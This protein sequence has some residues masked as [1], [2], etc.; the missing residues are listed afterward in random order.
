MDNEIYL[1]GGCFWGM[2]RLMRS[3]PGVT[4]VV[5]GYAQDRET[6]N[7]LSPGAVSYECVCAGGT[8]LKEAVKV[9]FD[10]QAVSL[11]AILFAYFRA[12]DPTVKNRQGHDIGE[13]YQTG[14][15]Y[16]DFESGQTVQRI[17]AVERERAGRFEVEIRP[18]VAFYEA[19]DYHQRY[20]EKNPGG[21][22]HIPDALIES[23]SHMT[24]DPG[25]YQRAPK[26][27][28]EGLLTKLQYDVTQNAATEPPFHN[29]YWN[30]F[31]RGIY[32]DVVTGEP[33][34]TSRDKFES[35][36]G[37]PS[38]SKPLDEGAVLKIPDHSH[39]MRRTEVKSRAGNSHLGHVFS[40][41]VE[42]PTGTRY[43]INSAALRFIPYEEMEEQGYGELMH[44]S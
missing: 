13:Q 42:S 33:L 18:L 37:W 29:A 40:G 8:G 24:F 1:A 9:T 2:E 16:T 28:L 5:S 25:M 26:E 19:E 10:P 14:I 36:C 11:D 30:R 21:Y 35:T 6:G 23:L 43:C 22:C 12:I 38:F 32:V 34:F 41:D 27:K 20:L 44:N 4:A 15:Y 3:L 17:A 31:E 39:H 7:P